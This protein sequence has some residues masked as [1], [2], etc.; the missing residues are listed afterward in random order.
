MKYKSVIPFNRTKCGVK[1]EMANEITYSVPVKMDEN[2]L[3]FDS[4]RERHEAA[5]GRPDKK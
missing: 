1:S 5:T 4:L 3:C 2:P